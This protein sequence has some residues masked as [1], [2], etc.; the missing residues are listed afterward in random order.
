MVRTLLSLLWLVSISISLA[1]SGWCQ[2][3]LSSSGRSWC[4][5]FVILW[6]KRTKS[7]LFSFVF[8]LLFFDQSSFLLK[9]TYP[10]CSCWPQSSI[11]VLFCQKISTHLLWLARSIAT[12]ALVGHLS[13]PVL[14]L[15][16]TI[17]SHALV[18]PKKLD[19]ILSIALHDQKCIL[20]WE[21]FY[22]NAKNP[23]VTFTIYIRI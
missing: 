13:H 22:A 17:S 3:S 18:C 5:L 11:C 12:G 19:C 4:F 15:V 8:L 20:A 16:R 10:P 21:P 7:L 23:E 6:P 14:W 9:T 2:L 1:L